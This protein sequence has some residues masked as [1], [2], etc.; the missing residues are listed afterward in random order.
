MRKYVVRSD[1]LEFVKSLKDGSVRLAVLDPPYYGIVADEWDNQWSSVREFVR[2]LYAILKVLRRKLTPDG[3]LLLFG[4]IGRHN[5]RPLFDL[6]RRI[7][8]KN[9]YH[10][11][12]FITWAKRKAY[13][14][15]HDYLFCREELVWYSASSVRTEVV[16]NIPLLDQLRGYKGFNKKYPAKSDYKRVSNVWM[17]IPELFK[18]RRSCEKPLALLERIVATH[19]NPRDLVIDCFCGLGVSGVASLKLGRKFKGAD[20]DKVAVH[21]A[22]ENIKSNIE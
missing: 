20:R 13:G 22:N 5:E 18:T 12:N 17:D 8:R 16:F 7:E 9:L 3:S 1:A 6:M 19:S 15:S 14:K 2:W 11:R 10:Y 21:L 4:G